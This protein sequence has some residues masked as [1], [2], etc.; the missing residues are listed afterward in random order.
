V[1][2]I[3]I[4]SQIVYSPLYTFRS[5]PVS[6]IEFPDIVIYLFYT[7]VMDTDTQ[8]IYIY[9]LLMLRHYNTCNNIGIS[10]V[11]VDLH[12]VAYILSPQ[13]FMYQLIFSKQYF[14]NTQL[15][16]WDFVANLQ[17]YS[18]II[19]MHEHDKIPM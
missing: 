11:D 10:E 1:L 6:S 12:Q 7:N 18:T 16:I 8:Y 3:A 13:L 4:N 15:L 9:N 5:D 14:Y 19:N 2:I 17:S